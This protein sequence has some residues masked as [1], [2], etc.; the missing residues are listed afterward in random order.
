M[1]LPRVHACSLSNKWGQTVQFCSNC[2][3][4]FFQHSLKVLNGPCCGWVCTSFTQL[5]RATA[6][7]TK[8]SYPGLSFPTLMNSGTTDSFLTDT[9]LTWPAGECTLKKNT[10]PGTA[11]SPVTTPSTATFVSCET[12]LETFSC[13]RNQ[14]R[15]RAMGSVSTSLIPT[16]QQIWPKFSKD[17]SFWCVVQKCGI[18]TKKKK[19]EKK[20]TSLSIQKNLG[21]LPS[22]SRLLA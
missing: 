7:I 3:S 20:K 15:F 16:N 21:P 17:S 9:V 18:L 14:R 10:D 13:L 12:E 4:H 22:C 8:G 11:M 1:N 19:E 6:G 2:N 5:K